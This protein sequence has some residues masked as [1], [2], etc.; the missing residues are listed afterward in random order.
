VGRVNDPDPFERLHRV[1]LRECNQHIRST[2]HRLKP[3]GFE[4][5][6]S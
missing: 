1:L 3:F 2:E 5:S 6:G 4:Q